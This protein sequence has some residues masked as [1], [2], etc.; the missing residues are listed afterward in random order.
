MEQVNRFKDTESLLS[1]GGMFWKIKG[2]Y[3][4]VISRIIYRCFGKN[5]T[6]GTYLKL[7]KVLIRSLE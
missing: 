7:Q 1:E 6:V 4:Y 2:K 5:N 3:F